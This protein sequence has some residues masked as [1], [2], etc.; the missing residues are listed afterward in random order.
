MGPSRRKIKKR[1]C[2]C[3]AGAQALR[4]EEERFREQ[5]VDKRGRE[6]KIIKYPQQTGVNSVCMALL[7]GQCRAPQ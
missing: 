2:L 5:S 6:H 4:E 7:P 3:L 1:F